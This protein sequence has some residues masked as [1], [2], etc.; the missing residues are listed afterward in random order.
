MIGNRLSCLDGKSGKDKRVGVG[1][2]KLS[3]KI[4]RLEEWPVIL[5]EGRMKFRC[6]A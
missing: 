2:F 5:H 1:K 4:A 6:E 3:L